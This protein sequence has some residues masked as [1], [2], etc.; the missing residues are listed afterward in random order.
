M[1]KIIP[2]LRLAV[3]YKRTNKRRYYNLTPKPE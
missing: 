2:C 1:K 3:T